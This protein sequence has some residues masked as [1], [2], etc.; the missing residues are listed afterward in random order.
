[1]PL[2]QPWA[3]GTAPLQTGQV[4]VDKASA[5]LHLLMDKHIQVTGVETN[6]IRNVQI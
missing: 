6:L 4:G 1:M 3:L 5:K 2:S